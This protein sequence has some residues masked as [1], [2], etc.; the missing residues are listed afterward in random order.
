MTDTGMAIA[1]ITGQVQSMD[2][3]SYSDKVLEMV[4]GFERIV[5][6]ESKPSIVQ[7]KLFGK[8]KNQAESHV[9]IGD[10]VQIDGTL[11]GREYNGKFYMEVSA[12]RLSVIK[13]GSSPVSPRPEPADDYGLPF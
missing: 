4:I 6:D 11:E 1:V 9:S 12:F 8:A 10:F 7:V 13:R 5:K 3:A 2:I